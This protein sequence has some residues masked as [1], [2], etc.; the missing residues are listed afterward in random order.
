MV[1]PGLGSHD[2]RSLPL[3]ETEMDGGHQVQAPR[4]Q[5]GFTLSKALPTALISLSSLSLCS[6]KSQLGSPLTKKKKKFSN[7]DVTQ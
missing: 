4:T 6:L 2:P 1:L 7:P 3:G 5:L